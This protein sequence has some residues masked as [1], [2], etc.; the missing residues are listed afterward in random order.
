MGHQ[1]SHEHQKVRLSKSEALDS[2]NRV[3]S[4][5]G[6]RW[7]SSLLSFEADSNYYIESK[8]NK[9]RV[10]KKKETTKIPSHKRKREER[11]SIDVKE[12]I[13]NSKKVSLQ[14]GSNAY[15]R[16]LFVLF[17]FYV[18]PAFHC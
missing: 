1:E 6:T 16:G 8:K 11:E 4:I 13:S 15:Q 18:G 3:N 5:A 12:R 7:H 10:F 2:T 14:S 9:E 17:S